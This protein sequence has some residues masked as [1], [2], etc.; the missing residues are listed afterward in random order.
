VKIKVLGSVV[1]CTLAVSFFIYGRGYWF[2]VYQKLAGKRTVA[3]VIK[4][5]GDSSMARLES[6]FRAAR[7][8][9]PPKEIAL[10]AIKDR[11]TLTLWAKS[12]ED[13]VL[14]KNYE[15]QAASGE[16]GPKLMEGDRQVPE[17]IYQITSLNPNSAYH[18]SMKL[19]YPNAFDKKWAD[20]EGRANPGTNIFIHGKAISVGCL[21]MGDEVIEELFVLTH[22]VGLGNVRVVI[23][24]T[25][26]QVGVLSPP[27]GSNPWVSVLYQDITRKYLEISKK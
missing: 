11:A 14:I 19:N 17:G 27:V 4:I 16:V 6:S 8:A 12:S 9:F 10:L 5:Y 24:P 23:S 26:P 1:L 3:E 15:V 25:N 2:P 21:A 13:W 20:A 7:V 22:T 18:L